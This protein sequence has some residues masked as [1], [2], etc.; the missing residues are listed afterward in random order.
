MKDS[1]ILKISM[2]LAIFGLISMYYL[3]D[4]LEI[5]ITNIGSIDK[6]SIEKDVKIEGYATKITKTKSIQIIEL[7]DLTGT[8]DVV[9][10]DITTRI[11]KGSFLSIT[12]KV[13]E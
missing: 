12:G 8:I 11:Q 5:T 3:S 2:I 1:T 9:I 4:K 6:Q 10:F 7:K 13:T